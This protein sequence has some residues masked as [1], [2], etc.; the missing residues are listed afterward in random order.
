[1]MHV[2]VMSRSPRWPVTFGISTSRRAP[3]AKLWLC[4]TPSQQTLPVC[5]LPRLLQSLSLNHLHQPLSLRQPKRPLLACWLWSVSPQQN[6]CTRLNFSV[7][8]HTTDEGAEW[9]ILASPSP[10]APILSR[11]W[12]P[13]SCPRSLRSCCWVT[14]PQS[15][16]KLKLIQLQHLAESGPETPCAEG[17]FPR[18][19]SDPTRCRAKPCRDL[20]QPQKPDSTQ[21][22]P[23]SPLL[24]APPREPWVPVSWITNSKTSNK[25][26][27]NQT[28]HLLTTLWLLLFTFLPLTPR[29]PSSPLPTSVPRCIV[30]EL[31]SAL[32]AQEHALHLFI[33]LCSSSFKSNVY[34]KARPWDSAASS[35]MLTHL[36]LP[37]DRGSLKCRCCLL[38]WWEF[39]SVCFQILS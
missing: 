14:H 20:C 3:D 8:G 19:G 29:L 2:Q 6:P 1:M 11:K 31:L 13:S 9:A 35:S 39:T 10:T 28:H 18:S 38:Y 21:P 34:R 37:K 7:W 16:V 25:T 22:G 15:N 33:T 5:C 23:P 4:T 17:P 12:L 26:N 32:C 27:R 36:C 30:P 24:P